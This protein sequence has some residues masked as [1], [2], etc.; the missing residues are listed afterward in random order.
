M[1]PDARV[2]EDVAGLLPESVVRTRA[3]RRAV[4]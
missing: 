4:D 2:G 3:R 1:L